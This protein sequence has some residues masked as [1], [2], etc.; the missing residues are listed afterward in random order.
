MS[1]GQSEAAAGRESAA[2]DALETARRLRQ[3]DASGLRLL[4]DLC[5]RGKLYREA[6]DAYGA[7]PSPT[8]EDLLRLGH[9]RL[10]AGEPASAREAF[11]KAWAVDPA[12]ADAAMQLGRLATDPAE[13][14]RRFAQAMKA[15]ATSPLPCHALGE[16]EAKAGAW[17]AAAEAYGE[18]IRRGDRSAAAHHQRALALQ[19]AGN[20]EAA[21]AA[22][23]EGLRE[24]PLDER[25]RA[26]LRSK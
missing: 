8:A 5:L 19:Q 15:D 24:H 18:A 6:A 2:I 25:L 17:A 21:E 11:E 22:L 10:Q 12:R 26:L 9:A 20:A 23:R 4:A 1:A 13:A 3:L 7:V 16:L 14:R